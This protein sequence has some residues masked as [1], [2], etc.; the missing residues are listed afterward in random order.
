M[1][2]RR[3]ISGAA[4]VLLLAGQAAQVKSATIVDESNS[5]SES[6]KFTNLTL[7]DS[8]EPQQK[9]GWTFYNCSTSS[10]EDILLHN[11][12][13]L[14][15]SLEALDLDKTR[16]KDLMFLQPSD[17]FTDGLRTSIVK[18]TFHIQK[19]HSVSVSFTI[20]L[21]GY[22]PETSEN[23]K[24]TAPSSNN[25]NSPTTPS[26]SNSPTTPSNNNNNRSTT[27]SNNNNSPK[28][29]SNNNNS[30][31]TT[32][33]NNNKAN[34]TMPTSPV[35]SNIKPTT[36]GSESN[37]NS[38]TAPS[39]SKKKNNNN[40]A[41]EPSKPTTATSDKT[42]TSKTGGNK[43]RLRRSAAN[44]KIDFLNSPPSFQ[45]SARSQNGTLID[46]VVRLSDLSPPNL[47]WNHYTVYFNNTAVWSLE[48]LVLEFRM[49]RTDPDQLLILRNVTVKWQQLVG[50]DVPTATPATSG[51]T[52]E[53]PTTGSVN[54]STAG[55]VTN[56]TVRT[57]AAPA[58]NITDSANSTRGPTSVPN[59]QPYS[60]SI[61]YSGEV[62]MIC[63]IVI[64]IICLAVSMTKYY[65]L[66]K[67]IGE[68]RVNRTQ[69][70]YSNPSYDSNDSYRDH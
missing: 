40:D 49:T 51:P 27:S 65:F 30:Q 28:T 31:P 14:E 67:N 18:K 45:V 17:I 63:V 16:D 20:L 52:S 57:T 10:L 61:S 24:P 29:T 39:S 54:G 15:G 62:V 58:A 9:Q 59:V 23:N 38:P 26:N 25:N 50:P 44:N 6:Y 55:P 64:L 34:A 1:F 35:D 66:Q 43:K 48:T 5:K 33:S 4:F 60:D 70:Q 22:K 47:Q 68:Y 32:N 8:T 42:V 37:K 41:T 46:K 56:T 13:Q 7:K 36:P 21:S 2:E 3:Y 69:A 53:A 12:N 11:K 19:Y